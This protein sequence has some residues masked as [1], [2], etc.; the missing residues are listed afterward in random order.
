[1]VTGAIFTS[2]KNIWETPQD[3]FDEL[4][5]EFGFTLDAAASE[6]NHKL[7]NYYTV[8]E[9]GL[10]QDWG[11]KPFGVIRPMAIKKLAFGQRS[12]MKNL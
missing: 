3:L 1:M 9:D 2:D 10:L 4:N 7:D 5:E 8:E 12:A 6:W 11:G